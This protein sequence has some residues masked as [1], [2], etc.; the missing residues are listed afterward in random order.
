MIHLVIFLPRQPVDQQRRADRT[1]FD[2]RHLQPFVQRLGVR[3]FTL[4]TICASW[5]SGAA[6]MADDMTSSRAAAVRIAC[7][8]F[9]MP[10]SVRE[11]PCNAACC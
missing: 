11:P 10:T 6:A 2:G 5:L 8:I 1:A 3:R 7:G 9:F 4:A